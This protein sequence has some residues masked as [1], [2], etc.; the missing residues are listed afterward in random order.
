[1]PM[2]PVPLQSVGILPPEITPDFFLAKYSTDATDVRTVTIWSANVDAFGNIAPGELIATT[3]PLSF[4]G[5]ISSRSIVSPHYITQLIKGPNP[6]RLEI[7]G[8]PFS[9]S[10]GGHQWDW[11]T[12]TVIS[13][14]GGPTGFNWWFGPV[15]VAGELYYVTALSNQELPLPDPTPFTLWKVDYDF[16]NPFAQVGGVA[17]LPS[18]QVERVNAIGIWAVGDYVVVPVLRRLTPGG[19]DTWVQPN[20]VIVWDVAAPGAPTVS[21]LT[22]IGFPPVPTVVQAGKYYY[23]DAPGTILGTGEGWTT[24]HQAQDF[25]IDSTAAEITVNAPNDVVA[26]VLWS[27]PGEDFIHVT[28]NPTNGRAI[29][30]NAAVFNGSVQ[31]QKWFEFDPLTKAIFKQNVLTVPDDGPDV[32]TRWTLHP[33]LP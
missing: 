2:A 9:N 3:P 16:S 17:S 31:S 10:R 22:R 20:E 19:P 27:D 30:A 13:A 26:E 4:L 21:D 29:S 18:N 6:N 28:V 15:D 1:M 23:N 25:P 12:N 11:E 32:F 5:P 24:D 7:F 33:Y 8:L 14:T